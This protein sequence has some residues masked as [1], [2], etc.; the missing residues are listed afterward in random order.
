MD[1]LRTRLDALE[2]HMHTVHQQTHALAG[3]PRWWRSVAGSLVGLAA[4]T[5][6]LPVG[7]AQEGSTAGGPGTMLQRLAALKQ[8]L[9]Y[10]TSATDEEGHPEVRITGANLR[11][12]NGFGS[13]DCLDEQ[14]EPI[15]D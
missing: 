1:D 4:L 5:W 6:A 13:T 2:S 12:V 14:D 8:K 11:I 9:R 7:T 3:R 15:P 10:L